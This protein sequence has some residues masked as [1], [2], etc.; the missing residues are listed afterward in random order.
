MPDDREVLFA[1]GRAISLNGVEPT[2]EVEPTYIAARPNRD[3][4]I[5]TDV[6]DAVLQ[7]AVQQINGLTMISQLP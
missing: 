1:S 7:K 3:G 4:K 5:T 6:Q 2:V